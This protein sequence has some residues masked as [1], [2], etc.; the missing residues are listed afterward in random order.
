M[1]YTWSK[2]D[3]FSIIRMGYIWFV[4]FRYIIIYAIQIFTSFA[5]F[6]KHDLTCYITFRLNPAQQ[7]SPMSQI[8]HQSEILYPFILEI[9]VHKIIIESR[10]AV[11][12]WLACPPAK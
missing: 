10:V 1:D 12:K 2:Q 7:V 9:S 6:T 5:L 3:Y 4:K 8:N 11:A